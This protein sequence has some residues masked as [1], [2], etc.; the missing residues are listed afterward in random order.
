MTNPQ[1]LAA[2]AGAVHAEPTDEQLMAVLNDHLPSQGG[3]FNWIEFA[4]AVLALRG[5]AV[6]AVEPVAWLID[7]H[8]VV[9]V[10]QNKK[11][12]GLLAE[13]YARPL[14]F[15]PPAPVGDVRAL[16]DE[17]KRL[18]VEHAKA[19]IRCAVALT[20]ENIDAV[21]ST[22]HAMQD[23]ID[24][25]ASLAA[26]AGDQPELSM[27]MFASRADYDTAKQSTTAAPTAAPTSEES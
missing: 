14:Y 15:R 13:R 26:G 24:R 16:A 4:R 17:C 12:L 27:S 2:G 23:A 25:L 21:S 10:A 19:G 8:G 18:A 3:T 1:D 7:T 11:D 9:S 5:S 20:K 6:H 22:D